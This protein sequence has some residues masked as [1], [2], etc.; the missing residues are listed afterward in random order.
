MDSQKPHSLGVATAVHRQVAR[1][2]AM[3]SQKPHGLPQL[4][5][6]CLPDSCPPALK[7]WNYSSLLTLLLEKPLLSDERQKKRL[8]FGSRSY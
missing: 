3:D 5:P 8:E 6:G 4:C 1:R 2:E 7:T